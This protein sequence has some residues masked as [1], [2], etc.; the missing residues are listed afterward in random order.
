MNFSMREKIGSNLESIPKLRELYQSIESK[1]WWFKSNNRFE[2]V[3]SM[4]KNFANEYLKN[5]NILLK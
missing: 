2:G 1:K 3:N 5:K 4:D